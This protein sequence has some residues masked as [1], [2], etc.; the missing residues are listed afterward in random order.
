MLKKFITL[1]LIAALLCLFACGKSAPE[2]F[3]PPGTTPDGE[4]IPWLE[5]ILISEIDPIFGPGPF[6]LNE[7]AERF[8][9]PVE[10]SMKPETDQ[11]ATLTG[12][13]QNDSDNI[14][15]TLIL[16]T[17]QT[18]Y[19]IDPEKV[20]RALP[21]EAYQTHVH[22]GDFPLPRGICLGDSFKKVRKAYPETPYRG[23][24]SYDGSA[25]LFYRYEGAAPGEYGI[26]YQFGNDRLGYVTIT[27]LDL[28]AQS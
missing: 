6:S 11:I 13:Y 15:F 9:E 1:A 16:D 19:E 5:S 21:M 12:C 17:D 3:S 26:C 24:H 27:W 25:E 7:L 18:W 20:D 14:W 2:S 4:T 8:G 22:G 23:G 28:Y 10:L